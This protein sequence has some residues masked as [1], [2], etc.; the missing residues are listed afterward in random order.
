[1]GGYYAIPV[2]EAQERKKMSN[3]ITKQDVQVQV[4]ALLRNLHLDNH[5][6]RVSQ[7]SSLY[8]NS[9]TISVKDLETGYSHPLSHYTG[10]LFLGF[11][12]RE[13]RDILYHINKGMWIQQRVTRHLMYSADLD[14]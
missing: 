11:T 4:E 14:N 5:E 1:M 8:G 12:K 6:A 3:R 7:G 13:T 2:R 10:N 9:T